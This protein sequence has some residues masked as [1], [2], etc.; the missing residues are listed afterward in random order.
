MEIKIKNLKTVIYR[1]AKN[2]K[3]IK[4]IHFP[5]EWF[6]LNDKSRKELLD[7]QDNDCHPE[8]RE[9]MV[10][11]IKN[12][13]KQIFE[14]SSL[15]FLDDWIDIEGLIKE[16]FLSDYASKKYQKII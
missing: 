7:W 2:Q 3:V 16:T 14:I 1:V 9:V 8:G 13:N 4:I 5:K 12:D 6:I 15:K 10:S 11:L